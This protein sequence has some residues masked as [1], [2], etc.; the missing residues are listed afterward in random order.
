MAVLIAVLM[1]MLMAVLMLMVRAMMADTSSP[2]RGGPFS[3]AKV[4]F[5]KVHCATHHMK[6]L[7]TKGEQNP[8]AELQHRVDGV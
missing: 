3:F 7:Q 5:G 8:D 6:S 1:A 4:A 2:Y